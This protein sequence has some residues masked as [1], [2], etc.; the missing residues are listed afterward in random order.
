MANTSPATF[1]SEFACSYL[2]R[3]H[4]H[5]IVSITQHFQELAR[6]RRAIYC[7]R[8]KQRRKLQEEKE[9]KECTFRPKITAV[10][11]RSEK[12]GDLDGDRRSMALHER[13]HGEARKKE[14]ARALAQLHLEAEYLRECTFQARMSCFYLFERFTLW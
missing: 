14:A 13:L 8:E 2:P 6:S 10:S 11:K 12:D 7:D 1:L 9:T 3:H 4:P 5:Q